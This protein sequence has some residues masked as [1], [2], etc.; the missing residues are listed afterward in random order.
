MKYRYN[1]IKGRYLLT[2]FPGQV[3]SLPTASAVY[4]GTVYQYVGET[5]SNYTSGYYYKCVSDGQSTPTYSW[6][7]LN[8]QPQSAGDYIEKVT[9]MPTAS[10]TE[11]GNEYQYMGA[12]DLTN[13]LIHAHFYECVSD[14]AT[15][16]VYSWQDL[17]YKR[18]W[19]PGPKADWDALSVAEKTMYDEAH[20]DDDESATV[21]KQYIA[22]QNELSAYENISLSTDSANPTIMQ[23]DGFVSVYVTRGLKSNTGTSVNIY[24]NGVRNVWNV[25]VTENY[26]AHVGGTVPVK[27][28]DSVYIA[29]ASDAT[30]TQKARYYKK[31][32]YS[33]RA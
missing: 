29:V 30:D 24:V 6:I 21:I 17:G 10:S 28:G 31:R 25:D 5:D 33:M 11:E 20:W 18:I 3:Q 32:D 27:K 19:G 22:D 13:G 12:D 2:E 8:V 15:P 1:S 7:H 14:G 26:T 23:Y 9:T 4:E 16:A